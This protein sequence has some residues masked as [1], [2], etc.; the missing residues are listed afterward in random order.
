[1]FFDNEKPIIRKDS[2]LEISNQLKEFINV[3]RI[4]S[5]ENIFDYWKANEKLLRCQ[6]I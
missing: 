6:T 1:M 5:K 3:A 4:S 2:T